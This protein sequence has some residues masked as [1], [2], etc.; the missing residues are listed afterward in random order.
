MSLKR[1]PPK[2]QADALKAA[3]AVCGAECI[4]M[5]VNNAALCDFHFDGWL[6]FPQNTAAGGHVAMEEFVADAKAK[7]RGAA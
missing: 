7:A 2:P 1:P 3:C 6:A 5:R 4:D